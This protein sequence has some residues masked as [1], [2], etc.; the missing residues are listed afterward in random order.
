V[1]PQGDG[2]GRRVMKFSYEKKLMLLRQARQAAAVVYDRLVE[3]AE[4][5]E[6]AACPDE[7]YMHQ[8]ADAAWEIMDTLVGEIDAVRAMV[9]MSK[10]DCQYCCHAAC[11]GRTAQFAGYCDRCETCEK[12]FVERAL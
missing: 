10:P 12:Y 11:Q 4:N 6:Y 9:G 1:L 2:E 3:L 5:E 8:E 7:N